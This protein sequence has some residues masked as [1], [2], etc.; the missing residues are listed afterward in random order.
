MN[1][2]V[3]RREFIKVGALAG[4]GAISA[5]L[6]QSQNLVQSQNKDDSYRATFTP[7]PRGAFESR[8]ELV[9]KHIVRPTDKFARLSSGYRDE[10][11][12]LHLS[13]CDVNKIL[14]QGVPNSDQ[15]RDTR[16]YWPDVHHPLGEEADK[17]WDLTDKIVR[18]DDPKTYRPYWE[19]FKA[20]VRA[21]G[22]T[23]PFKKI[24]KWLG[25]SEGA[26]EAL[27]YALFLG[28]GVDFA[29]EVYERLS[30][31]SLARPIRDS[32]RHDSSCLVHALEIDVM[33]SLKVSVTGAPG[34][35]GIFLREALI[36]QSQPDPGLDPVWSVLWSTEYT[37]AEFLLTTPRPGSAQPECRG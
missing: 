30:L 34:G 5:G 21:H 15:D 28:F 29:L 13:Q 10:N 20:A 2:L 35:K 31:Y 24:P 16:T 9:E 37:T 32:I 25:V 23:E 3:D 4:A 33:R 8:I 26:L 27:E 17:I 14:A 7:T 18:E 6:A 36:Y 1:R 12:L 11:R 19:A 22:L